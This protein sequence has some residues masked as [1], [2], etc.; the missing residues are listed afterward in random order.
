[1]TK[2]CGNIESCPI[3]KG[4]CK[5]FARLK[6]TE[7][8]MN[9]SLLKKIYYFQLWFRSTNVTCG[10][11]LQNHGGNCDIEKVFKLKN[12]DKGARFLNGSPLEITPMHSLLC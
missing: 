12:N 11:L 5:C 8:S 4:T 6:I 1:M 7:I 10:L 9:F 2:R 3:Y